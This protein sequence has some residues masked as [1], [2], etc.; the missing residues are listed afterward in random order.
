MSRFHPFPAAGFDAVE[1]ELPGP[2]RMRASAQEPWLDATVPGTVHTDLL[3]AGRI[4]DPFFRTGEREVQWVDKCDWEYCS[5]LQLD[6]HTLAHEHVELLFD[7]LDTY[8]EVSLNGARLLAAD[9][10]F[11]RWRVPIKAHARSGRNTLR[12]LLKSPVHA[13]LARLAALGFNPPAVV[14]W[15]EIGGLGERKISMFTRKAPYHYGWDWGPRLVTSGI[16]RPVRVHAWSGVRI[17]A[18]RIAAENWN[19]DDATLTAELEIVACGSGAA[20]LALASPTDGQITARSRV[21][22]HAGAQI[23]TLRCRVRRPRLWWSNGLGEPFLYEFIASVKFGPWQDRRTVKSGLRRVRILQP[24]DAQGAG[25]HV[26]LNGIPVFMKGANYIPCDSFPPRVSRATRAH[27]VRSAAAAHMNMLRVWGGGVYEEDEFYDLCDSH[28][29]LV[30][31]D[32]MFACVMYPGDDA[33][34]ESVRAEAID[35][36]KR[37][38]NHPCLALWAGNNEIDV[39]WRQNVPGG[40]WGWKERY[41]GAQRDVL[42]RAYRAIFHDILPRVVAEHDPGRFYWPSSPL[43]AWD[44]GDGVTH[45]NLLASRQSG[46]I[47]YWGV[48]WGKQPFAS[49]RNAIGRFM[50][51]YGF[52]SFPSLRSVHAFTA[53]DD[54]D[55]FS[56]VMRA[57]QRSAIGNETLREYMARDYPV[58]QSFAAFL[59]VSQVL[60][61][62]GVRTAMEA[63]RVRRPYCM[64]SLYWQINDCWPAASWSSIDYYGRW[65]ALH[66]FARRA[67]APV[68]LTVWLD[69]GAITIQAVNDRLEPIDAMLVLRLID[70][71]GTEL[72]SHTQA[73]QIAGNCS[74]RIDSHPAGR[75]LAS[76][77]TDSVLLHCALQHR[78]GTLAEQNLYFRPVKDLALPP[79]AVEVRVVAEQTSL[80]ITVSCPMLVKTLCLET[81][82]AEG[83]FSDNYFDLLPGVARTVRFTPTH[84]MHAPTLERD[85]R[86]WHMALVDG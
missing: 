10:M 35:N 40:G 49:Y 26:E 67:F 74:T 34:L 2:W 85:L 53:F 84:P 59:Y 17:A 14:D 33:F 12:V 8:A 76:V 82:A 38:R 54:R 79:A 44:G 86:V 25:F 16:W 57:H 68:L 11:R 36:V 1:Y 9:N 19:A 32:F 66:Y 73:A 83:H 23:C 65:K 55:V 30:W 56:E 69:D 20:E 48:W 42:W 43:A 18:L 15:S 4:P 60:Q 45:A 41:N 3:A 46:D 72:R 81:Q 51:E 61:A 22:L 77:P 52:Q 13:G 28:G 78:G 63:H 24:P 71:Q 47:H 80:A 29:I 7:G 39:A 75:W 31:Q 58:P 6:A 64:G 62:E 5:E 50:S 27:I 70:F 37:L 21:A